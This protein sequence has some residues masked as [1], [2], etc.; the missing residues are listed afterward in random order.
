MPSSST[1]YCTLNRLT[2]PSSP[3]FLMSRAMTSCPAS[4]KGLAQFPV[5]SKRLNMTLGIMLCVV[6]SLRAATGNRRKPN[7]TLP[8]KCLPF[9][10][11]PRCRQCFAPVSR[12]SCVPDLGVVR[13][14]WRS[15]EICAVSWGHVIQSWCR[16]VGDSKDEECPHTHFVVKIATSNLV[17]AHRSGTPSVCG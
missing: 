9:S 5:W 4:A 16:L 12:R 10:S 8:K 17:V 13:G 2:S 14:S 6:V 1:R 3:S 7:K 15:V 11:L